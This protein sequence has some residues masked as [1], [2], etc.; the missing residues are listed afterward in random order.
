MP[1]PP[2][3]YD[4]PEFNVC[5]LIDKLGILALLEELVAASEPG[6]SLHQHPACSL[7]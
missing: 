1:L 3:S 7:H 5:A 6:S 2:P 4:A